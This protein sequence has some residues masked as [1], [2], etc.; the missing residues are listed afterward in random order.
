M[1]A[2]RVLLT[3]P[4]H[5]LYLDAL[6]VLVLAALFWR[7]NL[8]HWAMESNRARAM[9][10]RTRCHL[11]PGAGFATLAE[12]VY[13]WGRLAAAKRG[14]RA[15]PGLSYR[16]RLLARPRHYAIRLGRAQWGKR[17]LGTMEANW[18]LLAPPRKGKSG[19][20]A[21]W[22]LD[23]PGAVIAT[24]TRADLFI[25]TAG[26]RWRRGVVHVF[27]PFGI[28]RVPSTFG[29]DV[30]A[31]CE[32]PAEAFTRADALIGPRAGGN[33]DMAFWQDKA[34]LALSAL[35]HA[36]ALSGRTVLDIWDWANRSGD[37]IG[38]SA[39]AHHPAASSVLRSVFAEATREGRS[40]DSIRM[41]MAKSLTWVA[42]PSVAAM[43]AGPAAR[44]FDAARFAAARGTLYL[45]APGTQGVVIEP[46]F[47]CFVDFAQR[48]ATLAGSRTPAG[49]L[50]PPLLLALDE[51]RQ[52]V[53]VPLDVWLADSAGKGVCIIAVAH[54]MG[55]LREGWGADGAATIWDTTNKIILPGVQDRAVLDE[56]AAVCG[57]V[58][59]RE[60]DRR[61][62]V[63]AVPPAFVSRLPARRAFILAAASIP[64]WSSCGPSG[65]ACPPASASPSPRRSSTPPFLHI[66]SNPRT[67]S[68]ALAHHPAASSVLRSV[69]AEATREGRSPDSIRMTMAKSLTWVA[70]PSVAAMVAGPAARPF[71]AARFAAARGTLYL[72]APGT[73]GVVIEPLF[74]CFVDFAQRQATL[75]G[76]RTPAGKLDP[77]LLLALDEV[78]QIVRVPLDVWLADSAGKGVCIIAVAH[79]MGQLREGWGADGA[80]TIW[81]TTNKIILPG[82]QDRAVL[83]EV[84]DVCGQVG[85]REGDRRVQ[86]QAVPPAFVSRLPARR[87]F[88]LAG[89]VNPV[90]VKL[91]PVWAR[92]SARLR[93]AV[94]PPV[95]DAALAPERDL[96]V[97]ASWAASTPD[98]PAVLVPV[99]AG[100]DAAAGLP[101]WAV[102]D[103]TEDHQA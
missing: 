59:A 39:L 49:K 68:L 90:V 85:A 36:A 60:G 24:S 81:D 62:Q 88:I 44:P 71:D 28:G 9:R 56:V 47:R 73:Q 21:D 29:W 23:W 35:L 84:A 79:G 43:V 22:I 51:V 31:G 27:N 2:A 25:N 63:Q 1:K 3:L 14:G 87:A 57:Q 94:A 52:I 11:R 65:P 58:G 15:R 20:L 48:Q 41:T 19:A 38:G 74:R 69:F 76:S 96:P 103:G 66:Y 34:A 95:L 54:G 77:P 53:R 4:F 40:P 55:Q 45:V 17:V 78:R 98:L 83:D 97:G 80:A 5:H 75:A 99:G 82:V 92:L 100:E 46:L 32:D 93:L 91:R 26:A 8:S 6:A 13:Q 86:V 72:V 67:P 50:D 61:V 12:L 7:F 16:Q 18:L 101:D 42:V 37:A 64:W 33:G 89:G 102:T 30:V 70:V 10:W